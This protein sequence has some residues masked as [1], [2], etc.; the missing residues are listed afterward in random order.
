MGKLASNYARSPPP[1]QIVGSFLLQGEQEPI[2]SELCFKELPKWR[3]FIFC[4]LSSVLFE[5][6]KGA[7]LHSWCLLISKIERNTSEFGTN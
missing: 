2:F 1:R 6:K 7:I 3:G 5:D 4:L